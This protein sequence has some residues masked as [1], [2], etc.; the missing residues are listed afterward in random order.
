MANSGINIALDSE[1]SRCLAELSEFPKQSTQKL[2]ENLFKE[3]IELEMEDLLAS[4][5]SDERDVEGAETVDFEDIKW[6]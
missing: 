3:A 2:A 6:D 5:I 1:T 4:K